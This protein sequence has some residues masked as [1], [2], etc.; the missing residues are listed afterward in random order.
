MLLMHQN[1]PF[2]FAFRSLSFNLGNVSLISQS[3][4]WLNI[5]DDR[6]REIKGSWNEEGV[7]DTERESERERLQ[8]KEEKS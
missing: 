5:N 1:S 2:F 3:I 7:W 4:S 8:G 6:G